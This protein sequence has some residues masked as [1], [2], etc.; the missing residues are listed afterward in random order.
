MHHSVKQ[1]VKQSVIQPI[2]QLLDQSIIYCAGAVRRE[3]K[4]SQVGRRAQIQRRGRRDRSLGDNRSGA[5]RR[6]GNAWYAAQSLSIAQL[7]EYGDDSAS[8]SSSV[9]AIW[10]IGASVQYHEVRG[11]HVY[12]LFIPVLCDTLHY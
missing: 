8:V 5:E 12:L 10:C 4:G 7:S 6:C 3:L 2:T 9:G 11:I 1:S